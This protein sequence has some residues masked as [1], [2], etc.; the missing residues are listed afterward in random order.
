MNVSENIKNNCVLVVNSCDDYSDI[1]EV[2]FCA[3]K[4]QWHECNIDIILN[5]ESKTFTYSGLN[6]N[7][8]N[9]NSQYQVISWGERLIATLENIDKEF[10]ITLFDDFLLEEKV[11]LNNIANCIEWMKS[12]NS[13]STF[14]FFHNQGKN[15]NDNLYPG[16]ELTGRFNDYR[17]NSAPAIWRRKRLIELTGKIDSPWAWECFGSSKTYTKKNKMYCA[18]VGCEDTFVYKHEL[19]GGIRRGKW[20]KSVVQPLVEKYEI[21]LDLEIRGVASESLADGKYSLQWKLNFL[22]LGF[23]MVGFRALI[24]WLRAVKKKLLR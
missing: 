11:K 20:V 19:G 22:V 13:I 16:F 17:L 4:E 3:L 18:K 21:D 6:L 8:E 23:R 2:F 7:V 10:V 12:D 15:K 24:F 1:W 5:T 14:Y 9:M